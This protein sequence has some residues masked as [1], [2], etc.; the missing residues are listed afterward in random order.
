MNDNDLETYYTAGEVLDV[1]DDDTVRVPQ[2]ATNMYM[3]HEY[4]DW[5]GT[6]TFCTLKWNG[7]ST[8]ASSSQK[9]VL[10]IWNITGNVWDDVI[11]EN[12]A[13]ANTDFDLTKNIPDLTN[14]KDGNTVITCRV[15]QLAPGA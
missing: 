14:Y 10:Q 3:I 13:G 1:A 11:E 6:N 12:E 2:T 7:Q 5:V 4:K 15:Y 8:T 9:V